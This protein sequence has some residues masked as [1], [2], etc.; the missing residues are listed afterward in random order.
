[1]YEVLLYEEDNGATNTKSPTTMV[2]ISP[3]TQFLKVRSGEKGGYGLRLRSHVHPRQLV[4]QTD[5][6]GI[7]TFHVSY[8]TFPVSVLHLLLLFIK[9]LSF[10]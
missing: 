10:F 2:P 1:M 7:P 3:R 5:E 6:L 8:L 4:A 9:L